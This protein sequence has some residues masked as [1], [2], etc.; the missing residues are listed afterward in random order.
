MF[1]KAKKKRKY[2]SRIAPNYGYSYTSGSTELSSDDILDAIQD[3]FERH[4]RIVIDFINNSDISVTSLK[5]VENDKIEYTLSDIRDDIRK[6]LNEKF[7]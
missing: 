7:K 5:T 6:V 1:V 3:L 4:G 2:F